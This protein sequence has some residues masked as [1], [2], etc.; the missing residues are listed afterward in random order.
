MSIIPTSPIYQLLPI[1]KF[2]LIPHISI[3]IYIYIYIYRYRFRYRY[4]YI[5][6]HIPYCQSNPVFGDFPYVTPSL[7]QHCGVASP[8]AC[9]PWYHAQS[10]H[11]WRPRDP[12]APRSKG[13]FSQLQG[14]T[15]GFLSHGATPNIS[16]AEWFT[17]LVYFMA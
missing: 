11:I 10:L 12:R 4:I 1:Y 8:F 9:V 5:H 3:S 7:K 16:I 14:M 2:R 15:G 6:I 13:I 17:G